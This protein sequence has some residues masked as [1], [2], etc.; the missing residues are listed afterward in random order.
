M[1]IDIIRPLQ[2]IPIIQPKSIF[3]L[4]KNEFLNFLL[5]FSPKYL[6]FWLFLWYFLFF[7]DYLV[8]FRHNYPVKSCFSG[9]IS[10]TLLIAFK[11]FKQIAFNVN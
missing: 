8:D 7:L 11:R 10:C 4:K 5:I 3:I 1:G 2:I 6:I 9:K